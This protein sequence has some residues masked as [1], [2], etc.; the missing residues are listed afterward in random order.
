MA[1]IPPRARAS[2]FGLN[3]SRCACS[4]LSTPHVCAV[5]NDRIDN[6][7][8]PLVRDAKHDFNAEA[9]PIL[10]PRTFILRSSISDAGRRSGILGPEMT[11]D[12][13]FHVL[14]G[15]A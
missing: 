10:E 3:S 5:V 14:S 15:R 12:G 4:S 1:V 11:M 9:G 6:A 13:R 8:M 7:V 2:V